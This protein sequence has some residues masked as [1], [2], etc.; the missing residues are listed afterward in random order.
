MAKTRISEY[1]AIAANNT[2][3]NSIN[4]AEGCAPSG[5]N[6]AIRQ[7]MADLKDFQQGTKGDAFLGPVSSS[8]LTLSSLT[9]NRVLYTNGSKVVATSDNM[10]FDGTTTTLNALTVDAAFAANGG[11]TLGNASGDALTINSSAVSIPNGLNFDSNTFVIDAANNNVGIGTAS[12]ATKLNIY[13]TSTQ[14]LR[15]S[16]NTAG[17]TRLGFDIQ[18]AYYNWIDNYRAS[19]A[20][21]FATNNTERMRI[22]SSGNVGIGTSSPAEKLH[23]VGNIRVTA[24]IES[25]GNPVIYS[26]NGSA[27]GTINSGIY[28][29]GSDSSTRFY[30]SNT[31]RMRIDSSGYIT[32]LPTYNNG[33]A[34]G[35]NMV[36]NSSGLFL[37]SV[38]ALKYKQDVR[39]LE[40]I[41]ITKFRPVRYKSKCEGDDQEKDHFGVIADEVHEAGVTELVNY[42]AEGEVEGF[43]YERLCVVLLKSIQELK[44][45]VDAQAER[46]AVLENK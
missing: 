6:N 9:A 26:S 29:V 28:L 31:E 1:D 33:S 15:I 25:T 8:S 21:A 41:D 32:S 42:G 37:R 43:Q 36:V 39:D 13:G 23:V 44:A 45:I 38:S 19:G 11:A 34:S 40:S 4:I 3:V 14:E 35:A 46:I 20:M 17:D 2:D 10:Q 27:A 30:T 7:V 5:I 16:T 22:D 12:P 24:D 18:G